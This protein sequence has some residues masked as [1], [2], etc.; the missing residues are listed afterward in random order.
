MSKELEMRTLILAAALVAAV[1]GALAG[2]STETVS[3]KGQSLAAELDSMG[4]ETKWI[5]GQRV[6]WRSGLPNGKPLTRP[7]RHTHCSAFVAAAAEKV[8]VYI[9]R[10]PQHSA[11][12]LANAQNA[13]LHEDGADQG[14]RELP[15]ANAAQAA[16]NDGELVVAS[17][18]SRR[19]DTPGHIAIVRPAARSAAEIAADGPLVI[20]AGTV[21]SAAI[22]LREGFAG[23][24]RALRGQGLGYF[25]H[26]IEPAAAPNVKT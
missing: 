8:G 7:G 12:L 13:W 19:P 4:V 25:A 1:S 10:P 14:W 21:N 17:Y 5:A 24:P 18:L 3:A 22:S 26:E 20:Q 15:D 6:D 23:H 16:A 9:L 11:V 2:P